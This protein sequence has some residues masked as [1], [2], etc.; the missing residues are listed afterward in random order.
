M[1]FGHSEFGIL[2]FNRVKINETSN[3]SKN[4]HICL[5]KL[6]NDVILSNWNDRNGYF[7]YLVAV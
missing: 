1:I 2:F 5:R 7:I 4:I 6:L 3:E